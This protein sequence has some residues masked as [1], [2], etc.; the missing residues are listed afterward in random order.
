MYNN[1]KRPK[2]N[3]LDPLLE[4]R[5]VKTLNPPIEDYWMPAKSTFRSIIDKV[6][7][8]NI[9]LWIFI[10]I[11]IVLL[12]YRYQITKKDREKKKLQSISEPYAQ[13]KQ[14]YV[15]SSKN[16]DLSDDSYAKLLL[17]L[18]NQQ[19]ELSIEPKNIYP[20]KPGGSLP[21]IR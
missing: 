14:I 18:Y 7:K 21:R 10:L 1:S 17:L 15:P 4:K 3:L 9:I 6:I 12:F 13:N 20:D 19:R 8:P 5:I 11:L 16:P 2:P